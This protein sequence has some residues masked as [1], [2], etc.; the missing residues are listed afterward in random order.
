LPRPTPLFSVFHPPETP[1][2][3]LTV[4]LLSRSWVLALVCLPVALAGQD[5]LLD[6]RLA[7]LN[8]DAD[9]TYQNF[10]YSRSFAGGRFLGQALYLRLPLDDYNEVSV[11]G[12]IRALSLG[13]ANLYGMASVAKATDAWY[14]EPAILLLDV[15][16]RLTGSLYVQRYTPLSDEGIV[17]W[18]VDTI[19]A[20]YAVT[21]PF[22][23][24][25]ALYAYRPEGGDW[26]TKVGPKAS[27]ADRL[28]ATEV[29]VTRVSPGESF[30]FLIRRL[31]IF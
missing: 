31:L 19:E 22:A 7:E 18:L 12:G 5:N 11:G 25:A 26:L 13:D 15:A 10:I 27:L 3:E 29:R 2:Q 8:E 16:G 23:L 1:D 9:V 6:L 28:G 30:E 14:V 17:Q 20:Q 4:A 21:G 24:G